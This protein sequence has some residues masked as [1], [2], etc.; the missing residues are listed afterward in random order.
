MVIDRAGNLLLQEDPG[1]NDHL[2]RVLAYRLADGARGVVATF[3]PALFGVTNPAGASSDAR[4]VLTTDEES[5]GIVQLEDGSFLF[6][7]QVHTRKGLPAG[8]GPG[9]VEEYVER[10][11]LL[12]MQVSDFSLVY[13][14]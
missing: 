12:R 9:T 4:A 1:G 8:S 5:S 14:S 2:A 11:Q 6:D 10:G 3:D 7:A 13:G